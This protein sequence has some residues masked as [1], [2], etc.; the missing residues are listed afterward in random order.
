MTAKLMVSHHFPFPVTLAWN[1]DMG[2]YLPSWRASLEISSGEQV[3]EAA[4]WAG[5]LRDSGR[6]LGRSGGVRRL[7]GGGGGGGREGG[8]DGDGDHLC[9]RRKVEGGLAVGAV[10]V[11]R[12]EVP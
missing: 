8:G 6:W 2:E 1:C 11:G 12:E 3:A 5:W 10:G 7:V 9:G 4:S